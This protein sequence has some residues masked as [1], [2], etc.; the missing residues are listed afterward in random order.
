M[1]P[2][3]RSEFAPQAHP[4]G[5]FTAVLGVSHHGHTILYVQEHPDSQPCDAACRDAVRFGRLNW[6]GSDL[7]RQEHS[8]SHT[9]HYIRGSATAWSLG[10][11]YSDRLWLF[12]SGAF[13]V[14]VLPFCCFFAAEQLCGF[15]W[16]FQES[17]GSHPPI[18]TGAS[19]YK[20]ALGSFLSFLYPCVLKSALFCCLCAPPA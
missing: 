13:F 11:P 7:T 1:W 20:R 14:G 19:A 8:P 16:S 6:L 15:R 3:P 4:A 12:A 5:T 10:R 18:I 17:V 2:R 9:L